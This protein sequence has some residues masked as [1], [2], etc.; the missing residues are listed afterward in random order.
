MAA[1][2][3]RPARPR[4]ARWTAARLERAHRRTQRALAI[5]KR[6]TD[7]DE[8]RHY[9]GEADPCPA[10]S[11]RATG[12]R[13]RKIMGIASADDRADREHGNLQRRLDPASAASGDDV[14]HRTRLA[15]TTSRTCSIT[16]NTI[17]CSRTSGVTRCFA[18]AAAL[19]FDSKPSRRKRR[20]PQ[21][22][23]PHNP[24]RRATLSTVNGG[25]NG[26][27]GGT[28]HGSSQRNAGP[29]PL[30]STIEATNRAIMERVNQLHAANSTAPAASKTA[31]G[32]TGNGAPN[33]SRNAIAGPA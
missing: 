6:G 26:R 2:P 5:P 32:S 11:P 9:R 16:P 17:R 29:R 27:S 10:R 4:A 8:E 1:T 19:P 30:S 3:R 20:R 22:R 12:C 7:P 23:S 13:P 18:I 14:G 31:T 25:G 24:R 21:P 15:I 33:A 28:F